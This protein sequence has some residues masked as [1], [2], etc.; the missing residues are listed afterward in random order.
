MTAPMPDAP[1]A[2]PPATPPTTPPGARAAR[3]T[4]G[5]PGGE[6]PRARIPGSGVR[7]S[8]DVR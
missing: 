7:G 4:I 3:N 8:A 2:A 6:R 5:G 1:A